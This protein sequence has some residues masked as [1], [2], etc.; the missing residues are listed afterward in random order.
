MSLQEILIEFSPALL[1]SFGLDGVFELVE[2]VRVQTVNKVSDDECWGFATVRFHEGKTAQDL[3][4]HPSIVDVRVMHAN[5]EFRDVVFGVKLGESSPADVFFESNV[6][7]LFPV[8]VFPNKVQFKI[9]GAKKGLKTFFAKLNSSGIRFRIMSVHGATEPGEKA[10]RLTR[11][12]EAILKFA[13]EKG[14]FEIPRKVSTQ[15]LADH[16]RITPAAVLEHIRKGS[17]KIYE[18]IF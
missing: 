13:L 16:F 7:T 17:K 11:K 12:Q 6:V 9:L 2:E 1:S 4:D 15:Y 14:Y 5:S 3:K 8:T 10:P 18:S